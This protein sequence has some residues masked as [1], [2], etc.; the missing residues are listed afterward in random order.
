[1]ER[2][3]RQVALDLHDDVGSGLSRIAVLAEVAKRDAAPAAVS[4]LDEAAGV[5]RA[6]RESM[7]EIVW[8]IDPRRDTLADLV[9][10]M[11]ETA[12]NLLGPQGLRVTFAAP[13]DD[14]L[15]GVGLAPDRRRHLLLILKEAV[16]NIARHARATTVHIDLALHH[17]RVTLRIRDDGAGFDPSSSTGGTGLHSFRSR[18]AEIGGTLTI[19]S[20]I[21]RGTTIEIAAP[22]A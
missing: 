18:A 10:R 14:T 1:M 5:A 8:A 22:L 2:V 15:S 16:T 3:R 11:R 7:S 9:H 4:L 12:F 13:E 20:S 21:G 17:H 19:E 6:M